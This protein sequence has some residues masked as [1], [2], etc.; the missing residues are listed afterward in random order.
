MEFYVTSVKET[1]NHIF[2]L[3]M[4]MFIYNTYHIIDMC[5][6]LKEESEKGIVRENFILM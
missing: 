5:I 6:I 1:S 3:H 4:R 2:V